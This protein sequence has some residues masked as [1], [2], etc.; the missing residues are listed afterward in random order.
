MTLDMHQLTAGLTDMIAVW[1]RIKGVCEH[2]EPAAD[3]GF[4][5]RIGFGR[6]ELRDGMQERDCS[7]LADAV[8]YVLAAPTG[9]VSLRGGNGAG[10]ST[11]L[12]ALKNHLRGQAYY[13]PTH[14]RLA[15]EFSSGAQATPV[16]PVATENDDEDEDVPDA[17]QMNAAEESELKKGYS[18]GERQLRVLTEIVANTRHPV[19]L[20]DEWDA[21]LDAAN[22]ARATALVEQLAQR[23]RV[24]EI[25][26]RDRR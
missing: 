9:L 3:P 12:A 20:L 11:L 2:I 4:A 25:S 8:H 5:D 22:R 10:K 7:S 19:Y 18:S 21:N 23:A 13:W 6:L 16:Q 24:V 17:A 15:F 1:T 26:H 14:D